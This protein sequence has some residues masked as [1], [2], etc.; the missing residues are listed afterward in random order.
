MKK[1]LTALAM[2]ASLASPAWAQGYFEDKTITYIIATNPGGNYDAYAR[3]IGRHLEEKLGADKIIFKNLPGAGHIIGANTLFAAEPDGLT[4]GTFNTGLIYAQILQ[5][6]GIKFKLNEFSWVGKA[7][8]DARAIVLSNNSGMSSF[9]DLMAAEK[10]VNFSA[11]GIGSASFTE[12][13]M[14]A[15]AL[16]LNIEMIPGYRGNEGEM[17]MLRGEVTGQIASL[18]SLQPFI[19]AGNGFVAVAIGG[20]AEPQAIEYAE[21]DRARAI[22]SLIDAMSN[23]GRL[24]AAPPGV[25]ADVL[26]ELRDGY[27]AVMS[28]PDFLAEAEK[29]G[30]SVE[31]ARGDEVATLVEAA[32]N[33]N[34]ETVAIISEALNV[35]IPTITVTS[36]ILALADRNKAVT[37]MSGDTEVT[38]EISGSRTKVTLNGETAERGDLTVGMNCRIDYDPQHEANEF[39]AIDCAGEAAAAGGMVSAS[40]EILALADGNK[41]VTFLADGTETKGM[42]SGKR[43]AVTV[44]GAAAT[45]KE[46]AAGMSCDFTYEAGDEIEFKTASCTSQ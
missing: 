39:K 29:L 30:L 22:V 9:E 19:D 16:D 26:E 31:P 45:R 5:R 15:D 18:G 21:T 14:L 40:S 6:E 12:T 28:D 2:T 1:I 35:K 7:A 27:M 46:L 23:L 38:G 25:P 32:L 33:Q 42:V 37:F 36:D 24:T 41:E 4:I 17:A 3:L 20:N 8:A 13:K 43:T 11:A 10:P 44:D 34:A